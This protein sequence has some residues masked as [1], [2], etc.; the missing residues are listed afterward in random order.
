MFM[1]SAL[2]NIPGLDEGVCDTGEQND[3]KNLLGKYNQMLENF[4]YEKNGTTE[5][6]AFLQTSELR[7][8][9]QLEAGSAYRWREGLWWGALS[10]RLS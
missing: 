4:K 3:L 6:G 2:T 7:G 8:A 9:L 10:L 1:P 5:N